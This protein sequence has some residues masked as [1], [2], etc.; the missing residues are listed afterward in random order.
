MTRKKDMKQSVYACSDTIGY[1]KVMPLSKPKLNES[2]KVQSK[3]QFSYNDEYGGI[4]SHYTE[5]YKAEQLMD[6]SIGQLGYTQEA[7]F[8]STEKYVDKVLG[9]IAE[10]Q[11]QVK[12]KESVYLNKIGSSSSKSNYNNNKNRNSF[13]KLVRIASA[14]KEFPKKSN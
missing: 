6:K 2:R 3:A 13:W 9:F 10:Y 12:F 1:L 11:T 7:K 8:T 4:S 14:T 5:N